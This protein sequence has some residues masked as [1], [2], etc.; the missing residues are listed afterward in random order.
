MRPPSGEQSDASRRGLKETSDANLHAHIPQ[1]GCTA[2]IVPDYRHHLLD[3]CVVDEART[4][5]AGGAARHHHTALS[6][7]ASRR[8]VRD[9]VLLG[10]VTTDLGLCPRCNTSG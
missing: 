6:R 9:G 5:K 2:L 1:V 3:P 4:R 10:V 8:R 7:D